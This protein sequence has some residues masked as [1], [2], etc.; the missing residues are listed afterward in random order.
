MAVKQTFVG[1]A[2]QLTRELQKVQR[3]YAKLSQEV[4]QSV[5]TSTKGTD[6][7]VKGLG[8][9]LTAMISFG[10]AVQTVNQFLEKSAELQTKALE[11]GRKLADATPGIVRNFGGNL[12]AL[13]AFIQQ[14]EAIRSQTSIADVQQFR[15]ALSA[16][17]S[18]SGGIQGPDVGGLTAGQVASLQ[19]VGA[20]ARL[21]PDDPAGLSSAAAATLALRSE[22]GTGGPEQSLGFLLGVGRLSSVTDTGK[23]IEGVTPAAIAGVASVRLAGGDPRLAARQSAAIFAALTKRT[24]DKTGTTSSTATINLAANLQKFFQGREDDPGTL[25]GRIEALQASAGLQEAANVANFPGAKGAAKGE[26]RSL[27][28]DATSPIFTTAQANLQEIQI[29][30]EPFEAIVGAIAGGTQGLR[31]GTAA[32]RLDTIVAQA[33]ESNQGR[34]Q[35]ALLRQSVATALAETGGDGLFET[36]VLDP[37]RRAQ[38]EI[39]M[40]GG[41]PGLAAQDMVRLQREVAQNPREQELL[42][43]ILVE[44]SGLRH[45]TRDQG[46]QMAA[47]AAQAQPTRHNEN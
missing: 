16:A 26:I 28:S 46:Q 15:G 10:A 17:L 6:S 18:S 27:L 43:R 36:M 38:F 9:Q 37:L 8:R 11:A 47:T 30:P 32:R 45:D 13:P 7:A 20:A 25:F 4:Q 31:V 23:I 42:E 3:E 40:A 22:A 35:R 39:Q 5:D 1:D 41:D 24:F 2:K 33:R 12:E 34:Q 21:F 19:A 14:S 29:T 44:I